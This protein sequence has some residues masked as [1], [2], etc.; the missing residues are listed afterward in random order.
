[1]VIYPFY[2]TL[3]NMAHVPVICKPPNERKTKLSADVY[4]RII[5]IILT[6]IE[7]MASHIH[8]PAERPEKVTYSQEQLPLYT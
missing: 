8:V 7:L 1:M 3:E 6:Y 2:S 5:S 4:I